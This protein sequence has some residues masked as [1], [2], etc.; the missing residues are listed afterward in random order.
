MKE[1]KEQGFA[2]SH[3]EIIPG[4]ECIAAP[5]KNY[6]YPAALA[7]MGPEN[8]IKHRTTEIIEVLKASAHCISSRIAGI[9]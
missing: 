8:R 1:I 7:V 9:F 4:I 6:N 3:G 2:V 5:I